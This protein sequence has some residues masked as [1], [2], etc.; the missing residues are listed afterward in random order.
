MSR[1]FSV[2]ALAVVVAALL[3]AMSAVTIAAVPGSPHGNAS[4]TKTYFRCQSGYTFA[5]SGDA[6]HCIKPASTE[7]LRRPLMTCPNVGGVGTFASTDHVRTK[8]MCTGRNPLTGEIAVERACWPADVAAGYTKRIV[9]GVDRCEKTVR[10]P[11]SI[12]AP[13]VAVQR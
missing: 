13:S 9:S 10:H 12:R 3:G 5:T 1:S 4:L 8:D 6:V 2:I 11:E 7:V